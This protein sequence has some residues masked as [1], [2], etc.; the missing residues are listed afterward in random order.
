MKQ[1]IVKPIIYDLTIIISAFVM[2]CKIKSQFVP[3]ETNYHA[4]AKSNVSRETFM[5]LC[6]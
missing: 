1:K 4:Y 5:L 3:R 6:I 2:F